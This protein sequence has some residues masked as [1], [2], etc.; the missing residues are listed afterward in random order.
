MDLATHV[1]AF[2]IVGVNNHI[3]KVTSYYATRT[4]TSDMLYPL[5]WENVA[6]IENTGF[7]VCYYIHKLY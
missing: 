5:L 7:K 1:L 2:M 4:A 3:K 6:Y